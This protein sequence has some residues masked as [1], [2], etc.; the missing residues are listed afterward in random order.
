MAEPAAV[1]SQITDAAAAPE[2]AAAQPPVG[3]FVWHDLMTTDPE[4]A[5]QYYSDLLGWTYKDFNMPE[6]SYRMI[7]AA[8]TEWG[9]F[10]PL[11]PAHGVPSHWI[12]YVA[13]ADV[14]AAAAKAQELGGQV[15]VPGTDIPSVGRF[16]VIASPTGAYISPYKSETNQAEGPHNPAP[17]P[18]TFIWHELLSNDPKEDGKFFSEVFGWRIEEVPMGEMG[19]YHLFKRL[20]TGTDAGGMMPKPPGEEGPSAWLPYIQVESADATAA[21]TEELGGKVWMPPMD[22]PNVGRFTVTSDPTGAFIAFLQP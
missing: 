7:H 6:G 2:A 11:D 4:K 21:R 10:M 13:V 17:G 20:D 16:A 8:G 19:T 15:A 5:H 3:R 9:G 14:D 1:N 12:S 18:G 22:I